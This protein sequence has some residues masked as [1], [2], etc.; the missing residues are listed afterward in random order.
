MARCMAVVGPPH[1]GKTTLVDALAGLEGGRAGPDT[2]TETRVVSFEFLGEAWTALDCPG[3]AEFLQETRDA[4]LAADVAV[5]VA[6]PDPEAAPLVAP[7]LRAVEAAGT[8]SLLFV[9]KADQPNGRLRDIVAGLQLYASHPIILREMPLRE[10][11]RIVGMV[12]LVSERAWKWREGQAASLV[13]IPKAEAD[14]EHE[15]HD[16]LLENLSE[17]DDWLLEEIVEERAPDSDAVYAICA[18]VLAESK[19]FEALFGAASH[20]NGLRRLMKAL[21]HEAPGPDAL[22]ARLAETSAA[23]AVAFG[24]RRRKH[25]G[26]MALLRGLSR[27]LTGGLTLGGAAVGSL[28]E[29]SGERPGA[30]AEVEPGGVAG[31]VKSDDLPI[32][33]PLGAK[34]ALATPD[35]AAP[36]QGQEARVLAAVSERDEAKLGPTLQKLAEDDAGLSVGADGEGGGWRVEVQGPLH[37]RAVRQTLAEVFGVET[38]ERPVTP[39]WRETIARDAEVHHRHRKQTGGAGQYA[40]VRLTVAPAPRGAGFVFEETVKGGAVPR[41]YIPAVE[42]GAREACGRGPLGFPVVDVIV[43]LTDGQHHSVD[44]SDMA[45]RTAA[46][47]AVHEALGEAAPV[48]LQPIH[49]VTI[50]APSAFTGGLTSMVS[51]LKGQVLGFDRDPAAPGWDLFRAL[52]PEAALPDLAPQLRAATQ[53]VG[54]YVHAFDHYEELY[55][56]DAERVSREHGAPPQRG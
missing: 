45:F 5:V 27:P 37:L 40:D 44:S 42:A 49:E 2:P 50:S 19:A 9:N 8:P 48:L 14:R 43:T 15:A 33:C 22:R 53:G 30:L 21:R 20:G 51:S 35:F 7:A 17:F 34:A 16:A 25:V 18:R 3:S 26:R 28:V 56:K 47:A 6:P 31:A 39:P 32:R 23:E 10:G 11:D 12:D 4:L 55:G 24:A 1:V 41:N 52:L 46:R 13:A 54:R 29:P 38:E 36:L